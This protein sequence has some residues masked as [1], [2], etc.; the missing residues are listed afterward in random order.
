M[1]F[2]MNLFFAIFLLTCFDQYIGLLSL[3]VCQALIHLGPER[4]NIIWST[5]L[6]LQRFTGF[7]QIN[8]S[9]LERPCLTAMFKMTS[10]KSVAAD[11]NSVQQF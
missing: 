3:Q 4:N 11:F 8:T 1:S 6:L 10:T 2:S 9:S 5:M 7:P